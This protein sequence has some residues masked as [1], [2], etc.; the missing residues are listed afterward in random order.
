MDACCCFIS[1]FVVFRIDVHWG[2]GSN[3]VE[4]YT[5]PA[6]TV[7]PLHIC[8][9]QRFAT[10]PFFC[11]FVDILYLIINSPL[12][13]SQVECFPGSTWIFSASRD[14]SVMMWDLNQGDE[15]IQ[16]F[17]GHELVVNGLAVSPDGSRLCTGSRD[18]SMC[19]WDIESGERVHK[20][21]VSRNLVSD[22]SI[23]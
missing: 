21:T 15:P 13:L 3:R 7:L 6:H 22:S 19:L 10:I 9:R 20:N 18:N 2:A 14:K 11:V 8:C 12:S 16:E 1:V 17:C 4:K 23:P 5:S